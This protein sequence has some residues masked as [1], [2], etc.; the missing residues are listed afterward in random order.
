MQLDKPTV[1]CRNT[2][3]KIAIVSHSHYPIKQPFAGGLEAHT[4]TLTKQLLQRGHQVTLYAAAGSDKTL[5]YVPFLEPT[6]EE[7]FSPT[8]WRTAYREDAYRGLMEKLQRSS[9][10]VVHNNSL[11]YVPL[12]MAADL[13]MPMVTVLH[14]PPFSSLIAGFQ[15]AL[16]ARNHCA[17][18]VSKA[19]ARVWH[20]VLPALKPA[21]VYN[22]VDVARWLPSYQRQPHAIWVG[23]IT[24]E[25]GTHLAIQAALLADIPLK[26]CGPIHDESYFLKQVKPR[27]SHK[28]LYLGNLTMADLAQEFARAK[29][30][31][32]TPC[33]DEPFGLVAAEAM[34]SGTPI[35]SF[36]RGA[37]PELL[38]PETG[39]LVPENVVALAEAI[40]QAQHLSNSACRRRAVQLFSVKSM[41]SRYLE[42]YQRMSC[43]RHRQ[44]TLALA[45]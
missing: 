25:K 28:T 44:T 3:L 10:D 45:S 31:I 18:A 32:C 23:R 7:L 26:L 36:R 38:T 35:A 40:Q 21:M 20:S 9:Y 1:L 16:S 42:L 11:H 6:A 22:G 14:T 5:P 43:K 24:P 27:L 2:P 30:F 39:V 41:V 33:W 4:H 13:P 12:Q 19:A 8:E 29:V 37:L 15:A 34:A 17:I